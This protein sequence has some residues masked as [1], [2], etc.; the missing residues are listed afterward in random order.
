MATIPASAQPVERALLAASRA[1]LTLP[2]PAEGDEHPLLQALA[3]TLR[4][5]LPLT[6]LVLRTCHGSQ[7]CH[8]ALPMP[9]SATPDV[10][11]LIA[12]RDQ[13]SA[14]E[15]W[16]Q[17]R[18]TH[19]PLQ[20]VLARTEPRQVAALQYLLDIYALHASHLQADQ[21][22][23][24]ANSPLIN[25]MP[26]WQE[27]LDSFT[28]L[29]RL[30]S[31][32]PSR[33][34]FAQLESTLR[35][36][37]SAQTVLLIQRREQGPAVM[38]GQTPDPDTSVELSRLLQPQPVQFEHGCLFWYSFP[39]MLHRQHHASLALAVPRP[40]VSEDHHLMLFIAEQG[41]VLAELYAL[42][43]Q[44]TLA[45]PAQQHPPLQRLQRINLR[46]QRQLRQRD[47]I[48]RLLQQDAQKDPLTGLANRALF[49]HRLDH[50]IKHYQRYPQDGFAILM[51][52]LVSLH[53]INDQLGDTQGDLLLRSVAQLLRLSTRQNDLVARLSG[54]EF[55]MLLDAS[56]STDAITPVI[57]RLLAHLSHPLQ[58]NGQEVLLHANLGIATVSPDIHDPAQLLRQVD[59]ATY[60]ARRRGLNQAVFYSEL[61]DVPDRLSPE[62]TLQQAIDAKRI[63][64]YVQ[65]IYRIADGR[66]RQLEIMARLID[67]AG[68]V[69]DAVTFI[70]LAEQSELIVQ[71]DHM[72]LHHACGLLEGL[73]APL[74]QQYDLRI[75]INLSGKHLASSETV[76][77][78]LAIIQQ[79]GTTPQRLIFEFR[80]RDL[81]RRDSRTLTL[82]HELRARGV[83][84]AV[85][86]FGTGFGS[87]NALFHYPVDFIKID[88]S[89]TQRLLHAPR[90]RALVRAILEISRDLGMQVIAEGVEEAAQLQQLQQLH[91]D[92]AQGNFYAA[93]LP[94][95]A[96]LVLLRGGKAPATGQP[97]SRPET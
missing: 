71:I 13:L 43:H 23:T 78:L 61:C 14:T 48:N 63:L 65:P 26:F 45:P 8:L 29:L 6:A 51:L 91:C 15:G 72:M 30:A 50:A 60:Q 55:I 87:L 33:Q 28:R 1:L 97:P 32:L 85:D 37:M 18:I 68:Q 3:E 22:L 84:I 74:V 4:R 12:E 70:P 66:V 59:L 39:L 81:M 88:D 25:R 75:S 89:F 86:D 9:G 21:Q 20:G 53:Q 36:W 11:T 34:L 90:D 2:L 79:H 31:S 10:D 94:P 96:M 67:D 93:P 57:S 95:D 16:C 62:Q 27:K 24:L 77:A 41:G 58:L 42:R 35:F 69:Q 44:Q 83:G 17:A 76:Q 7:P 92:L 73:L 46:L 82:L 40:L 56:A 54:N 52:E 38:F 5:C 64:P 47:E 80:E 49:L 19:G